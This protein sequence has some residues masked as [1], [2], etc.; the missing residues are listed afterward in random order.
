M[1]TYWLTITYVLAHNMLY[2]GYHPYNLNLAI[3]RM[4]IDSDTRD[5]RGMERGVMAESGEWAGEQS[6]TPVRLRHA[7]ERPAWCS[8]A[9]LK[10]NV[11]CNDNVRKTCG[12]VMCSVM[13]CGFDF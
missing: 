9:L 3:S 6:A 7:R 4:G 12:C 10:C 1:V 13:P 5:T 8:Q 11:Y 2:L